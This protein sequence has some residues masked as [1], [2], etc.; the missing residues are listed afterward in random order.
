VS[1]A[2]WSED[3]IERLMKEGRGR[4]LK[5]NYKPWIY[6]TS[7][8]SRGNSR[9]IRSEKT[10]RVHH[11]LSEVE[12]ELFLLLEWSQEF[13]DIREQYPLD[14]DATQ[15]VAQSL[16]LRHPS[17]PGTSVPAVMTVDFL[18]TTRAGSNSEFVA[19]NAKRTEEAEDTNS[20]LKLEIQR[21]TLAQVGIEHHLVYHSDIP[22]QKV[23]NLNWIR[24]SSL[25]DG[26]IE[27]CPGYFKELGQSMFAALRT[28]SKSQ[29]LINFCN[30]FDA[31]QGVDP[32]TGLRVARHL[33]QQRLLVP[34]LA[35]PSL[36]E[37]TLS[38][39]TFA[40]AGGLRATGGR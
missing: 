34:D 3:K 17:Y 20:L 18:C 10:G 27:P 8:S 40:S 5:E 26:E 36:P 19:F 2:K 9:R 30:E 14:R 32:G 13:T 28:T 16:G 25:K 37:T 38:H 11:L 7:F 35:R 33:M 39:F 1:N 6:V 12:F 15:S 29:T 23:A 4:G 31:V 24:M 22:K 21:A